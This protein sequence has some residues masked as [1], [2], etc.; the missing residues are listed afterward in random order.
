MEKIDAVWRRQ[1]TGP[2]SS[3][4]IVEARLKL[5]LIFPKRVEKNSTIIVRVNPEINKIDDSFSPDF[6]IGMD[7]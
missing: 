3:V 4:P 5:N 6:I 7:T 1:F 2:R